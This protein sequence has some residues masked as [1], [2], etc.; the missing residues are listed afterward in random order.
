MEKLAADVN[1]KPTY[2]GLA[3]LDYAKLSTYRFHYD[4]AL[5]QWPN[6]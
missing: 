5:R 3:V 4:R 2:V 1:N 6:S